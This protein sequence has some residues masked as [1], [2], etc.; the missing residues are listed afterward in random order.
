MLSPLGRS[1]LH[2]SLRYKFDIQCLLN[3]KFN[4]CS[5]IW[6]H[7]K[8]SVSSK[9]LANVAVLRDMLHFRDNPSLCSGLFDTVEIDAAIRCIVL[10]D[11]F[12]FFLHFNFFL[13]LSCTKCTILIINITP[14]VRSDSGLLAQ[15][16]DALL[17]VIACHIIMRLNSASAWTF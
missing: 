14:I 11:N 7:Y 9:L 6:N 16:S 12:A 10:S 5:V 4:H 8:S 3:P 2:C 1:A 13:L 15:Q 17:S